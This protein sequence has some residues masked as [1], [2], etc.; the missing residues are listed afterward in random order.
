MLIASLYHAQ[1]NVFEASCV[2]ESETV[3][4]DSLFQLVMTMWIVLAPVLCLTASLPRQMS[5][6]LLPSF[7]LL[8]KH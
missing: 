4:S 5:A 6:V 2:G 7:P 8:G 3:V 1:Q